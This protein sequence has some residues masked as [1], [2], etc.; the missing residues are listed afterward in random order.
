MRHIRKIAFEIKLSGRTDKN[1]LLADTGGNKA[2]QAGRLGE[3]SVFLF[4]SKLS[5]LDI[6]GDIIWGWV[7]DKENSTAFAHAWYQ[8]FDKRGRPYIVE[9]F[10]KEW[11]GIIPVEMLT[12]GEGRVPTFVLSINR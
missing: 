8:L 12:E 2:G 3:D 10:S 4:F 9:G 11:N 6:D 7:V 1:R 5:E